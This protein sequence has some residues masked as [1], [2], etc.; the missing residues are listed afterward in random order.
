MARVRDHHDIVPLAPLALVNRERP[1]GL[2][3]GNRSALVELVLAR[4]VHHEL[5]GRALR[6]ALF[7]QPRRGLQHLAELAIEHA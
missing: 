2:E 6:I 7:V 4:N 5:I 1:G 3:R